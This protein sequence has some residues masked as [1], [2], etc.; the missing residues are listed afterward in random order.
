MKRFLIVAAAV[1]ALATSTTVFA[2]SEPLQCGKGFQ[3]AKVERIL[4]GIVSYV[5]KDGKRGAVARTSAGA[6]KVGEVFCL[7][8]P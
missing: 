6:S 1:T 3:E 7:Q 4:G 2:T 5:T 8:R